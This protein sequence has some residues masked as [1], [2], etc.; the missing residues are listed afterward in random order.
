MLSK[1]ISFLSISNVWIL[2]QLEWEENIFLLVM[3]ITKLN[4]YIAHHCLLIE[5]KITNGLI[6]TNLIKGSTHISLSTTGNRLVI[7]NILCLFS[8]RKWIFMVAA[9]AQNAELSEFMHLSPARLR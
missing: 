2:V 8:I 6:H 4:A 1:V 7:E 9:A 5:L 3:L